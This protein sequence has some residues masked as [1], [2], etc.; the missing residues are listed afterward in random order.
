MTVRQILTWPD[1][2]LLKS[3]EQ[4]ETFDESLVTLCNDMA[5]TIKSGFG[6]GLAATQVNVQKSVC[7]LTKE[8]VP[9]LP[10]DPALSNYIVLANP[11][12]K[13]AGKEKFTWEERCLSIPNFQEKVSRDNVIVLS[14]QDTSGK[15]ITIE[16]SGIESGT[17]QHEADHLVG[18]LFIHRLRGVRRSMA[19]RKLEKRS[20]IKK[21][22]FLVAKDEEVKIGHPL[23]Q[24]RKNKKAFGRNK[25]KKK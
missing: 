9:S 12:I 11:R 8:V 22:K 20:K 6:V 2:R 15:E 1:S 4:V 24:R 3:A 10:L 7:V 18:K 19:F 25:K 17:V 16:L 21:D 14:Y 23:R 13:K 5:D